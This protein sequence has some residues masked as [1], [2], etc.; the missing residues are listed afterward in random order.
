MASPLQPEVPGAALAAP[1]RS[2]TVESNHASPPYQSGACPVSL[3]SVRPKERYVRRCDPAATAAGFRALRDRKS[4]ASGLP[5]LRTTQASPGNRT[6]LAGI[7]A[8]GLASSRA[9]Q[10][11]REESNPR[12]PTV[13]AWCSPLSYGERETP[14]TGVEP[15]SPGR[16]PGR[17][18][19]RV[20]G[21]AV[22]STPS[23]TRT[24]ASGVR[25]RRPR[26]LDDRG[27]IAARLRRLGSNQH[28]P[29]NNRPSYR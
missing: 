19:R 20:R 1:G 23:G 16:Q 3:S 27:K 24:R 26:P 12:T 13:G 29:G 4:R 5:I 7:T 18:S 17:V 25:D 15:A 8:R 21:R 22:C 9:T 28:S 6:L 10:S 14:S 11:R 2:T